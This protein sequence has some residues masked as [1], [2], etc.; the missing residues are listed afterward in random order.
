MFCLIRNGNA[1]GSSVI[2]MNESVAY[3]E[4]LIE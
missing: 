2:K 1:D 3:V 4:G